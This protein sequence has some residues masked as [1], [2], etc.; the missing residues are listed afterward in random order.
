MMV[1]FPRFLA[2]QCTCSDGSAATAVVNTLTLAPTSASS[3]SLTFAKMDPSLGDL[4]CISLD[5]TL[6]AQSISGARNLAPST[7]LLN[8]AD[9]QYSPTGRLEYSFDLLTSANVTGPGFSVVKPYH[10]YYGPDL[11][12]AYGQPDDT[13][14][15]GPDNVISGITGIK[16]FGANPAYLGSGSITLSYMISGG[17]NTTQ[18][19]LNYSQKIQ[20]TYWGDFTLTYYWCPSIPLAISIQNFTATPQGHAILLQWLANNSNNS[21]YEIQ[22]STDGKN[23]TALTEAEADPDA[24]GST[25]K[26]QYQYNP[27]Q[28]D[29][30][31]LYFRIRETSATGKVGYSQVLV[32]NKN[33]NPGG[34]EF[35]SYQV[36]PNPITNSLAFRF[37]SAQNG[38]F[39]LELVNIAGQ[40]IQQKAV[41]LAGTNE[42]GMDLN[43][44]PSKG[45]YFLRTTDLTHDK[46]YTSKIYVN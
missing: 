29:V 22:T 16:N 32:V 8:P 28:T 27:D 46:R 1:I 37:N 42:I 41:T 40:V 9:P 33:G 12:G 30:D 44:K 25:A 5:Y 10:T 34:A 26:Y 35:I 14:T 39:R 31:K 19:G 23:F 20:T 15:Y 17:L 6:S 11:L 18:G 4:A 38:R 24:T 2:A 21:N 45:L 13:I 43:P 3:A 36:Y 7:A